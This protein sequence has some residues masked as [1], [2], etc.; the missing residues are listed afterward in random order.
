MTSGG[1]QKLR[2][3]TELINSKSSS[4]I[5]LTIL[6]S[7]E[8]KECSYHIVESCHNL[9]GLLSWLKLR[10]E[11]ISKKTTEEYRFYYK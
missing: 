9:Y 1:Y 5:L 7:S 10:V 4:R 3:P 11:I 6:E 8:A 2:I